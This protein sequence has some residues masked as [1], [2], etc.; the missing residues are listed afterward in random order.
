MRLH[1]V[2]GVSCSVL[3]IF[4]VEAVSPD[5]IGAF[6]SLY[7]VVVIGDSVC[8]FRICSERNVRNRL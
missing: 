4:G 5:R 8:C 3:M 1:V 2:P 6:R 7:P